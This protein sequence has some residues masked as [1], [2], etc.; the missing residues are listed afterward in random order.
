MALASVAYCEDDGDE[1]KTL[2]NKNYYDALTALGFKVDGG[3]YCLKLAQDNRGGPTKKEDSQTIH[4]YLASNKY[5]IVDSEMD[6]VILTLRGTKGN[7]WYDNFDIDLHNVGEDKGK[8]C[9]VH[10]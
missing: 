6:V 2:R 7:E 9:R 10:D 4:Y 5:K 8:N 1:Y 3:E